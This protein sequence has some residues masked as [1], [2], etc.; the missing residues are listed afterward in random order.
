MPEKSAQ[1]C[2]TLCVLSSVSKCLFKPYVETL[3]FLRPSM[4]AKRRGCGAWGHVRE[5]A[6]QALHLH[7]EL[8]H[9]RDA[10]VEDLVP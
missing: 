6:P 7:A 4:V 10:A 2:L 8:G 3:L 1:K 5:L 9:V